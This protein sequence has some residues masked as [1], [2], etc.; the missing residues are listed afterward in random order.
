MAGQRVAVEPVDF[1]AAAQALLE[2]GDEMACRNAVSRVYYGAFH[3]AQAAGRQLG[4]PEFA[5]GG[6]HERLI[7]LFLAQNHKA[8]AYRLRDLHRQR[9]AADYEIEISYPT[10]LAAQY[11]AHGARLLAD[12]QALHSAA[13]RRTIST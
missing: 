5:D 8:L 1:L 11:V 9:C 7:G 6:T 3:Q 12:L 2:Q 13:P 4:W 10:G